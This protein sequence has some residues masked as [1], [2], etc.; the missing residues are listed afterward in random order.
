MY[1]DPDNYSPFLSRDTQRRASAPRLDDD[2]SNDAPRRYYA[3]NTFQTG[4]NGYDPRLPIVTDVV[5]VPDSPNTRHPSPPPPS[6][7]SKKQ[8]PCFIPLV[9]LLCIG[10][11]VLEMRQNDYKFVSFHSNPMI[12]PSAGTLVQCGAKLDCLIEDHKQY[13]RIL[14]PMW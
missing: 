6:P 14:S 1:E 12:G 8:R 11:F 13:W 5:L 10:V 9:V 2:S 3:T 4:R 7:P